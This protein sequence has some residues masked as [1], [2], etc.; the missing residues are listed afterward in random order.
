MIPIGTL[1]ASTLILYFTDYF[2]FILFG[3]FILTLILILNRKD[4]NNEK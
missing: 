1:L 3:V 2:V 4:K